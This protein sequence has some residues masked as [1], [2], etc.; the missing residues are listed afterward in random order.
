MR[1]PKCGAELPEGFLYCEKCGEEIHVVPDYDPSL[2]VAIGVEGNAEPIEQIVPKKKTLADR[3]RAHQFV[4]AALIAVLSLAVIILIIATRV[5]IA[6]E[7][8]ATWQIAMAEKYRKIGEYSKAITCY[9]KA[10]ALE[11]DDVGLLTDIAEVYFLKNDVAWYEVTLKQILNHPEATDA[12][13]KWAREMLIP[14]MIKK[15]DFETV[16]K[17]LKDSGDDNLIATYQEYVAPKPSF[18]LMEGT[19]E[20]IQSLSITSYAEGKIY[21]SMD[22]TVP[23][24]TSKLYTMPIVLDFGTVTIKACLINSYGVKSD[25]AEA[26]YV[27]RLPENGNK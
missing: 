23:G 5:N 8:S 20:D 3:K 27:I 4:L 18:S 17:L 6:H 19:Y 10:I 2:D 9:S 14:L 7:Q 26:T 12:Q 15:G 11:Q 21:Y 22:G 24:E 1:C 13:R 25:I 16:Y